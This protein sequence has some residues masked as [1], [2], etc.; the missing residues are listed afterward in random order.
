MENNEIKLTEF[1]KGGGCGCKIPPGELKELLKDVV[2]V[3][4]NSLLV[5][6]AKTDDA[7]VYALNDSLCLISTCDFFT[8][9]VDSPYDFGRIAAANAISDVY[10]MGGKPIL[11]LSILAW[12]TS[13]IP[14][15]LAAEVLKG[16]TASCEKAGITLAG[17][18]SIE[19]KEPIF[20]LAVNGI[21][22]KNKIKRNNT[23]QEDDLIF[24]TKPIG[25]GI[26]AT[27]IKRNMETTHFMD[28]F[29]E[30]I[31]ELNAI[32]EKLGHIANV[33]AMTDVTGFG[34][35]GH[36]IEM[37]DNDR[38]SAIIDYQK[39]PLLNG[40]KELSDAWIYPD[41]TMR[42]WKMY[43]EKVSGIEGSNLLTMCDPQTNGGLL[44]AVHTS[45]KNEIL[46]LFQQENLPLYEIGYFT[47]KA[48]FSINVK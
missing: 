10:A 4:S 12:P 29:I 9:I 48:P 18:H 30:S 28:T 41:N 21:V 34:L 6:N 3:E 25:T 40:V 31:V 33:S 35:L 17:G 7:A 32:G 24:L 2:A 47:E 46:T 1:T 11:A 22:D 5:G 45:S 44:F 38:L 36:L 23:A 42:N 20:G 13:L 15:K 8:P 16:A 39:I 14:L 37:T 43:G 26:L 19:N 27:A